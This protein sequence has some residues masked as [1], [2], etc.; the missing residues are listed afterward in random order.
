M[1]AFEMFPVAY[2]LRMSSSTVLSSYGR[3]TRVRI[4]ARIFSFATLAGPAYWTSIDLTIGPATG[5]VGPGG[6]GATCAAISGAIK[7]ST[8]KASQ[9]EKRHRNFIE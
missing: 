1:R 4:F 9:N 6:G 3:P 8:V 5:A 7:T 2:K